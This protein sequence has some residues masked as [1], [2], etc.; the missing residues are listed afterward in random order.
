MKKLQIKYMSLN[1]I[2]LGPAISESTNQMITISEVITIKEWLGTY[3]FLA[4]LLH[5]TAYNIIR[6][7]IKR[8][9]L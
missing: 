7:H 5:L 2:T 8:C 4:I 1:V 9:L 3:Q 6:D